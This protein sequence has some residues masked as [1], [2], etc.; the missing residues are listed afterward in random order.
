MQAGDLLRLRAEKP[1]E[2]IGVSPEQSV[3]GGDLSGVAPG[4][5]AYDADGSLLGS[6]EAIDWTAGTM[7]VA[8]NPFFE[9]QIVVPLR[10]ITA[11]N[12]RELFLS[13]TRPPP[14]TTAAA[15]EYP[16]GAAERGR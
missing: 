8:T 5:K 16:A 4:L 7:R 10:L 13:F 3:D 9:E 6:V 14:G 1:E 15:C 12:A 2:E 11:V